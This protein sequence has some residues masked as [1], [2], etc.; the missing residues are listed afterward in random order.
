M[1][2]LFFGVFLEKGADQMRINL[3]DGDD[4]VGGEEFG[5]VDEKERPITQLI[6]DPKG[7]DV[8]E[9]VQDAIDTNATLGNFYMRNIRRRA[10]EESERDGGEDDKK[11]EK[12]IIQDDGRDRDRDSSDAEPPKPIRPALDVFVLIC[13]PAEGGCGHTPILPR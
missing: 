1:H 3:L 2:G 7:D 5:G 6:L 8:V 13:A 4:E 11:A 9:A 12:Y 10:R